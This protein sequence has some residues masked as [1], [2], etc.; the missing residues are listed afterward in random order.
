MAL[1]RRKSARAPDPATAEPA[2]RRRVVYAPVTF[3]EEAGVRYLHFGTEW[4]Q[5]AM[6]LKAPDVIELEYAQQ[7]MIGLLF[8]HQPARI[9]QLG[10]GAAALTKFCYRNLTGASVTAVELNAGVVRAAR[11]M[12]RLPPDDLRLS[13]IEEDAWDFVGAEYNQGSIDLLHI[14]LYDAAARGPVLDSEPF[15]ARCRACLRSPAVATVNLFGEHPSF[16]K[17]EKTLKAAFA[18]RVAFLPEV[19]QGNRVAVA[20]QGPDLDVSFADLYERAES[21]ETLYALPATSWVH[22]LRMSDP[23]HVRGARFRI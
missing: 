16:A 19:H 15:Y 17:N 23:R 11:A 14:D 21:I 1:F 18:G 6:R 7:M 3:S 5:G 20:F 9:V 13:V 22:G 12:F 10:L 4:V 2:R 8:V